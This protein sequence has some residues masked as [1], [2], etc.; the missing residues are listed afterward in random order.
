MLFVGNTIF[1]R[2]TFGL[3][4]FYGTSTNVGYLIPDPFLYITVQFQTIQFS[5]RTQFSSIWPRDRTLSD[6]I[7]PG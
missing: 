3:D 7:T 2:I 4:W 6:A 1:K 5:L